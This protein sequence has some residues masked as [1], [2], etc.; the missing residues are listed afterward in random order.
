MNDLFSF[1]HQ[2]PFS[3]SLWLKSGLQLSL[4]HLMK[5]MKYS[6]VKWHIIQAVGLYWIALLT[7]HQ[8]MNKWVFTGHWIWWCCGH[9]FP[10]SRTVRSTFLLFIS[11]WVYGIFVTAKLTKTPCKWRLSIKALKMISCHPTGHLKQVLGISYKSLAYIS[12]N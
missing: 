5:T 8:F 4:S 9:N 3:P 12:C 6:T 11:H 2:K 1:K 10:T 7:N